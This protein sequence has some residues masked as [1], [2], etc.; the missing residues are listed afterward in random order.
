MTYA[1][2][3]NNFSIRTKF[4]EKLTVRHKIRKETANKFKYL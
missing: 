1:E 4:S 3:K 2:T